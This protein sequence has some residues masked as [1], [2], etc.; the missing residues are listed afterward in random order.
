MADVG[1]CCPLTGYAQTNLTTNF[2][3]YRI[4]PFRTTSSSILV[5]VDPD[6]D[7]VPNSAVS[8]EEADA[9]CFATPTITS[10]TPGAPS[11]GSLTDIPGGALVQRE[12][13]YNFPSTDA[14]GPITYALNG[15]EAPANCGNLDGDPLGLDDCSQSTLPPSVGGTLTLSP[16]GEFR[17]TPLAEGA[18]PYVFHITASGAGST[19]FFWDV[20]VAPT[21]GLLC[22]SGDNCPNDFNFDQ[23]DT[24]GDSVGDACDNCVG[25]PN[26][27]ILGCD[28]DLDG[29][30]NLC[31]GDF[32]ND[33]ITDG[34]DFSPLWLADF[35]AGSPTNNAAG[36]PQGTNMNCDS[37]VDGVDFAIPFFLTQFASG[38]PGPS[39]LSCA[40]TVP[41]PAP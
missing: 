31:D 9:P 16:S 26:A 15:A 12:Y 30:G 7:G 38:I 34:L 22:S 8:Q 13:A 28:S 27:G 17:W 41:C 25:V 5:E 37:V 3:V 19:G 24:D 11:I 2:T 32:N 10:T 18:I 23:S 1:P 29:Y 40:G 39:G 4:D 20:D 36:N 14:N 6:G 35:M 21:T 33:L